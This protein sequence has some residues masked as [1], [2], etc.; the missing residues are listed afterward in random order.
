[1]N[2]GFSETPFE[3]NIFIFEN[4]LQWSCK[5]R[6]KYIIIRG[7]TRSGTSCFYTRSPKTASI[8]G[9][10]I[11]FFNGMFLT[12]RA[13]FSQNILL[14]CI[15]HH[16]NKTDQMIMM[17]IFDLKNRE[18]KFFLIKKEDEKA[19]SAKTKVHKHPIQGSISPT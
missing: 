2:Q 1:M 18:K 9:E 7:N 6:A 14:R 19:L 5:K 3:L 16:S 15:R 13:I 17:G 4:I 8:C 11:S 10:L 12:F